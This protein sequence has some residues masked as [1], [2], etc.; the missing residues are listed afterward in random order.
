[1]TRNNTL[2]DIKSI[3]NNESNKNIENINKNNFVE[4]K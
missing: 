1:M 4:E 3:E 2:L